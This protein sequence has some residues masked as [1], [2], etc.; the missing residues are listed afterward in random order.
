MVGTMTSISDLRE[1]HCFIVFEKLYQMVRTRRMDRCNTE[2]KNIWERE[3]VFEIPLAE[4]KFLLFL[5]IC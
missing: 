3:V 5:K 1:W 2:D 4:V